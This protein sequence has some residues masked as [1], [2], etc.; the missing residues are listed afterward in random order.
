MG[1]N[2]I[3]LPPEAA[4]RAITKLRGLRAEE[5]QPYQGAEACYPEAAAEGS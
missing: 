5:G 3:E 1:V 4:R 2:D